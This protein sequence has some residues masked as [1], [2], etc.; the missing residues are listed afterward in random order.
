MS[1]HQINFQCSYGKGFSVPD[2]LTR[3]THVIQQS[4]NKPVASKIST[5]YP[6]DSFLLKIVRHFPNA[7][8][9]GQ[10]YKTA[11]LF[12]TTPVFSTMVKNLKLCMLVPLLCTTMEPSPNLA[13]HFLQGSYSKITVLSTPFICKHTQTYRKRP[14]SASTVATYTYSTTTVSFRKKKSSYL[15]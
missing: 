5:I 2:P 12:V 4:R 8:L 15:Y 9:L 1:V 7:C 6:F 14:V 13:N 10:T 3:Q 11:S